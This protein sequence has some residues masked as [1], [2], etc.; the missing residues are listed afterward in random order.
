MPFDARLA[1]RIREALGG[2]DGLSERQMFGGLAFLLRG[3]MCLGVVGAA[4]MVRVG[5]QAHAAALARPH[6]RPMDFTGRPMKGYVFVDP[7]GTAGDD[8]LADWVDRGLRFAAGLP[9][10]VKVAKP[11]GSTRSTRSKGRA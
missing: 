5:P 8:M 9:P 1:Q 2:R 10:K 3:H 4:L 7:P 6:V 11:T